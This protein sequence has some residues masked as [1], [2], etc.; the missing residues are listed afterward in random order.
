MTTELITVVEAARRL[1]RCPT[2]VRRWIARK[3]L[4]AVRLGGR[5]LIAV[6]VVDELVAIAAGGTGANMAAPPSETL[7]AGRR[8][9]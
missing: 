5:L 2:T 7:D 4:S 1:G 9:R 3:E 8:R 6:V